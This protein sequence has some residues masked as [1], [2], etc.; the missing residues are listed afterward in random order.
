[1]LHA[2]LRVLVGKHQGKSI[3]LETKK[4]LVGR[5]QD[6]HLRPNSELI[7]RHHCVFSLD[8]YAVRL[9]DLGSTNGTRVNGEQIRGEVILRTGDRVQL[10]KLEF[11]VLIREPAVV[12]PAAVATGSPLV[13][14]AG[15]S[16][17]GLTG[18]AST[19]DSSTADTPSSVPTYPTAEETSYELPVSV[20][21]ISQDTVAGMH[22][23][24]AILGQSAA[25]ITGFASTQSIATIPVNPGGYPLMPVQPAPVM[26]GYPQPMPGYPAAGYPQPMPGYPAGYAAPGYPMQPGAYPGYPPGGM[27]VQPAYPVA[28]PQPAQPSAPAA[29]EN[30][31][32]VA[33]PV[34]LPLPSETGAKAPPPPAAPAATAKPAG[35]EEKPSSSAADIIKQYLQRR[36]GPG[37]K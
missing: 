22:P 20:D 25:G 33:P 37:S 31:R 30:S 16:G 5:E 35:Q 19:P 27:P 14:Q 7:S 4:F 21:P 3:P 32:V 9:R 26:G 13:G 11:E 12:Q 2:E 34:R 28:Q 24:T 10:G 36:S 18:R 29:A 8:D 6:C 23:D 15:G 1:M 17:V